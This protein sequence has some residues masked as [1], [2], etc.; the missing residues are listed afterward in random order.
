PIILEA[1]GGGYENNGRVSAF[2]GLPTLLGWTNHEGQWRGSNVEINRRLPDIEEIYTTPSD[3]KA[4]EL[5]HKWK[6]RYLILGEAE[7]Q[8]I[9]KICRNPQTPCSP[10]RALAK[11][12]RFLVPLYAQQSI[13][14][15][16]VP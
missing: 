8:Y 15:Y 4:L 1:P 5:M 2:T 16:L 14:V 10:E 12:D 13:T 7:R 3:E 11:F 9:Q 6:I